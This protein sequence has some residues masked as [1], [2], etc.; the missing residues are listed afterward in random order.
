MDMITDDVETDN[1]PLEVRNT[2]P[3]SPP[4]IHIATQYVV[5]WK[6]KLAVNWGNF[7]EW[8]VFHKYRERNLRS[9]Y[10]YYCNLTFPTCISYLAHYFGNARYDFSV[11]G[12]L[13]DVIGNVFFP[14]KNKFHKIFLAF[15]VFGTAFIARPVGALLLGRL[16]DKYG[17]KRAVEISMIVMAVSSV[18]VGCIP[19]F[20][21][22][23]IAAPLLLVT[24]RFLQGFAIGGQFISS[25]ILFMDSSTDASQ[26]SSR[27]SEVSSV[28][29]ASSMGFLTG[30]LFSFLL[31][32]NM[33]KSSFESW[34]WRL[35]FLVGILTVIP[36]IYL[37]KYVQNDPSVSEQSR[38]VNHIRSSFQRFNIRP[39]LCFAAVVAVDSCAFYICFIWLPVFMSKLLVPHMDNAF[40]LNALS[41]FISQIAFCPVAGRIVDSYDRAL[42]MSV[43]SLALG[44]LFPLGL[45][46]LELSKNSFWV[47]FFQSLIG[48]HRMLLAISYAV[49]FDE[50]FHPSIRVTSMSF[51]FNASFAIF[52]GFSP[53]L[54]TLLEK[55]Q[56]MAPS[57]IVSG[58]AIFSLLGIWFSI[59][60]HPPSISLQD[61]LNTNNNI[62]ENET[63]ANRPPTTVDLTSPLLSD[64]QQFVNPI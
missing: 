7:A 42:I 52:G 38:N 26:N 63:P 24:F 31:R 61:E 18:G 6:Q 41:F 25:M 23:N 50:K 53:A 55:V 37:R 15:V 45:F 51:S 16:G 62:G 22:I 33:S 49:Y 29:L 20:S 59:N 56:I 14:N 48:G 13:A 40:G 27:A 21:Q 46:I 32:K 58:A 2:I 64:T 44:T 19:S 3:A 36:G 9:S 30:N 43:S 28:R 34:G 57:Y 8:Y 5:D 11:F 12:F 17:T 47:V 10:F 54:S 35:P 4:R 39:M 1:G 60:Y